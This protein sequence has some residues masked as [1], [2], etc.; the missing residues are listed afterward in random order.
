MEACYKCGRCYS[1]VRESDIKNHHA[2]LHTDI[3][4]EDFKNEYFIYRKPYYECD[5]CSCRLTK[6]QIKKHYK[7]GHPN[8]NL[9]EKESLESIFEAIS[10][11]SEEKPVSKKKKKAKTSTESVNKNSRKQLSDDEPRPS[12]RG[13]PTQVIRNKDTQL[14][15]DNS[16]KV[17][18]N[19]DELF[20][21]VSIESHTDN[22]EMRE[23]SKSP[24]KITADKETQTDPMELEK[25]QAP[26]MKECPELSA[27]VETVGDHRFGLLVLNF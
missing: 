20:D 2:K 22:I 14:A 21:T 3:P 25:T 18:D 23:A 16:T 7:Y 17:L 26:S 6:K 24:V 13:S 5:Y 4:Y 10:S 1:F 9:F 12:M 8:I 19:H 15:N 27:E 11:E